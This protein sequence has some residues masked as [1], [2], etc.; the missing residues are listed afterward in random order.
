MSARRRVVALLFAFAAWGGVARADDRATREA[1]KLYEEGMKQY[2]L[3]D[4][5]AALEAFKA[6]YLA[7]PDAAFLF[8]IGQCERFLGDPAESAYAYR[9]FLR[10]RPDAPNRADV[11]RLIAEEDELARRAEAARRSPPAAP[12]ASSTQ[13][14]AAIANSSTPNTKEER[15]PIYKRWWLWTAVAG[16]VAIAGGAIGLAVAYTTPNNAADPTN[17]ISTA[18]V[19]FP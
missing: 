15:L 1:K 9:A 18:G 6:G 3:R 2:N 14:P 7:R 19:H 17:V 4:F 8:N 11:E 12:G 16:G 5:R 10:E 13:A